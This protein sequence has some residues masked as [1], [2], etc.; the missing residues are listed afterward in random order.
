[1]GAA[2][3]V[4][5]VDEAEALLRDVRKNSA[6]AARAIREADVLLLCTGAG[7][8]ADSGLAVYADVA[9]IEPYKERGLEYHDICEPHWQESEP[10][11][12]WG[13]WGMCYN[14]YRRTAPH[15]G[16]AIIRA[17]RDRF[18]AASATSRAVRAWLAARPFAA[19]DRRRRRG[20]AVRGL[21]ERGRVL[22]LHLERRRAQLRPLRGGRGARVPR[23]RRGVPV[24]RA[25]RVLGAPPVA[26]AARVRVRGRRGDDARAGEQERR[27]RRRRA[28]GGGARA[29][30]GRRRAD[31]GGRRRADEGGRRRADEGG[32]RRGRR[33]AREHAL[34]KLPAVARECER[35]FATNHPTCL[36]CGGPARPAILMFGD[37]QWLDFAAQEQRYERWVSAVLH[38][39]RARAPEPPPSPPA[40]KPVF[41]EAEAAAPSLEAADTGPAVEAAPAAEAGAGGGGRRRRRGRRC[42]FAILEI[43][44]GGNVATVRITAERLAHQVADAGGEVAFIRV[45]PELPCADRPDLPSKPRVR[46]IPV[47]AKGL[48]A[49]EL[50]DAAINKAARS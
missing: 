33:R 7:F 36:C 35:G 6:E 40:S 34:A 26:R 2:P 50:I 16:Y 13:F 23:Q 18:F 47:M 39:A 10:E 31:E 24:R 45:N 28:D 19:R 14:D 43:G 5:G 25:R 9:D 41:A 4:P 3:S 30:G 21:G 44:C 27:M 12:F 42:V 1:M 22:R 38:F 49:L 17:W 29:Q 11:L 46:F 32:R 48:A 37:D 8:S 20:R 15:R